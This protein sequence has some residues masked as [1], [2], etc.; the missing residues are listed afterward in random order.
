MKAVT[1]VV[2]GQTFKLKAPGVATDVILLLQHDGRTV[3]A[4]MKLPSGPDAG[5]P[6][7]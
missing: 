1:T 5:R 7:A 2:D 4:R 6:R 3:L